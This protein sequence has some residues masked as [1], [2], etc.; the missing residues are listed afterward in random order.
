MNLDL[1]HDDVELLNRIKKKDEKAFKLIFDKYYVP[2]CRYVHMSLNNETD[3]EEIVQDLF[4]Y[5]WDKKEQIEIQL[6]LKAYLFQAVRNRIANYYRDNQR[7]VFY[8]QLPFDIAEENNETELTELQKLIEE[9]ILSLPEKCGEIFRLSREK[10]LSNQ[11]IAR[12]KSLSV[13]T[14]DAQICKAL[15]KIRE[16]LGNKY[17]YLW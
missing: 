5:L 1:N 12:L 17:A 15:S 14:V 6:T 8:D 2:L 13:R 7:M 9:A 3:S 16:Y 4:V 11:D 10:H